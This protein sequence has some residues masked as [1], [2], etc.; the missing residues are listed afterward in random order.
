MN[1]FSLFKRNLLYKLKRKISIEKDKFS[2]D[3]LDDLFF[4]YGSDKANRFRINNTNGHGFSKYYTTHLNNFKKRKIHILELGSYAGASAAAFAK[5]FPYSKIY[6]FDINISNFK[7][8]SANIYVYG[9]D[10]RNEIKVF[11]TLSHIFE[12]NNL[13]KF[14]IIIDD[15]SHFLSDIL[16]SL[17]YFFKFLN[18]G[19]LYIIEDFKHP[20]YYKYNRDIDH[21]FV[22]DLL[23][24]ISEKEYF[25]SNLINEKDQNFIFNNTNK[26]NIYKGNLKDS[27]ICFIEKK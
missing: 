17:N 9:I 4:Y 19:G 7:Y 16:F 22:D 8:S 27:D 12:K 20:N 18:S 6:C 10:I 14:D 24:K 15:G 1:F 11:K 25:Q 3:N 2:N 13:K 23:K 21:I 26:I 5:Y